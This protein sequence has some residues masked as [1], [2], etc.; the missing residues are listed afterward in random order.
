M[1]HNRTW[2]LLV[3]IRP[4]R[5]TH[6]ERLEAMHVLGLRNL[7]ELAMVGFGLGRAR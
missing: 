4:E 3:A 1:K 7:E 2:A 5:Y 6:E